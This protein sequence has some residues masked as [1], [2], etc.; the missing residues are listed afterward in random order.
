MNKDTNMEDN[1]YYSCTGQIVNT[2]EYP[3]YE[4]TRY[5][6]WD[7]QKREDIRVPVLYEEKKNCC[8]CYACYSTCPQNAISMIED[9]EGFPYPCIDLSKCIKC[10]LCEKTC[11]VSFSKE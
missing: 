7:D 11:P 5:I 1:E 8:G 3:D 4:G 9:L 2:R 10:Y 6:N